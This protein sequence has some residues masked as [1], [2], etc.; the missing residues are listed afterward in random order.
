M[1]LMPVTSE[2]A[3]K[4]RQPTLDVD[5][6]GDE[7]LEIFKNIEKCIELRAEYMHASMQCPGGTAI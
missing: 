2:G 4:F 3:A 1:P 5:D 6:I 7:L